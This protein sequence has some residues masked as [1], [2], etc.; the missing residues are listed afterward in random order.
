[1]PSSTPIPNTSLWLHPAVVILVTAI[2]SN[3]LKSIGNERFVALLAPV[4]SAIFSSSAT[5]KQAALKKELFTTRQE[6][7]MTSSQDE[8]AKWAKLRRKV[9]KTLAD[10]EV[11]SKYCTTHWTMMANTPFAELYVCI[12]YHRQIPRLFAIVP[13]YDRSRCSLRPH[14]HRALRR[15][16]LLP[17]DADLLATTR[18]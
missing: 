7:G 18:C 16:H 10:L 2:L 11:I 15:L 4:H 3:I 5:R 17:Q 8:F 6:L 1:M 9:D 12:C 13:R 14:D